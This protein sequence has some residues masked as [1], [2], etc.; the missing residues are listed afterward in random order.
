M[1][2]LGYLYNNNAMAR[3]QD[4]LIVNYKQNNNELMPLED[5]LRSTGLSRT[6]TTD[7]MKRLL[8]KHMIIEGYDKWSKSYRLNQKNVATKYLVKLYDI[9]SSIENVNI[10]KRK[11]CPRKGPKRPITD[12]E[13]IRRI[14]PKLQTQGAVPQPEVETGQALN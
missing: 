3:I 1:T 6:A 13:N 14:H 12:K 7:C 5:I 11:Y 9:V 2:T 4:V 8:S 10:P